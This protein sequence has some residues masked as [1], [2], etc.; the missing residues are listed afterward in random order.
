MSSVFKEKVGR[1]KQCMTL[2]FLLLIGFSGIY[3]WGSIDQW[4]AVQQVAFL[5]CF[6][7]T[8]ILMGL[9]VIAWCYYRL[10]GSH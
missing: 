7:L 3:L 9:H 2:N 8:A 10:I 1:C 5:M 4:L 6:L